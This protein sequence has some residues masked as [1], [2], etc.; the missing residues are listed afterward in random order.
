MGLSSIQLD[1]RDVLPQSLR[2]LVEKGLK[3]LAIEMRV[4]PLKVPPAQRF[5][6]P[7]DPE[8]L[9]SPLHWNYRFDSFDRNHFARLGLKSDSGFILA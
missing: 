9:P 4:L 2:Q 6:H 8:V 5:Y 7:I 3:V 1:H